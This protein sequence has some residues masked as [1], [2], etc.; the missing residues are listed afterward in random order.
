[1]TARQQTDPLVP[2][3]V[4]VRAKRVEC[5]DTVTLEL[6]APHSSEFAFRPGQFNMLYVYGVGEIPVSVSGD[7]NHPVTLF[8]TIRATGAVSRA[9]IEAE[10]GDVLGLRG[11]YGSAWPLESARHGDVLILAGGIGLAPLRP[12]LY[13]LARHRSQYRNVTL[14][15][16]TRLPETILYRDLLAS[17][18][19]WRIDT[20][21]TVDS[22]T[23][24]WTG[25]VGVVTSQMSKAV[26]DPQGTTVFMC[27]PEVMMRFAVR[28]VL[29][30]G[31]PEQNVHLSLERNMK[32]AIR[33]CGRCQLGPVFVCRDGPVFPLPRIWRLLNIQEL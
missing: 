14:L 33:Q 7:P 20:Y 27:G 2:R 1:M 17:L 8:H 22:A 9:L 16:G 3:P 28:T 12:L 6:A 26:F 11:P 31:I 25:N 24:G 4:L 23:P 21:V 18:A 15:Y 30:A 29:D 10:S 5:L 13:E 32:C 19:Q